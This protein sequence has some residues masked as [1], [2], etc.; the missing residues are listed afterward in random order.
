MYFLDHFLNR[1]SH[2]ILQIRRQLIV[3]TI[4]EEARI[5][6]SLSS[7]DSETDIHPEVLYFWMRGYASTEPGEWEEKYE[8]SEP[9]KY[10]SVC[11]PIEQIRITRPLAPFRQ[12]SDQFC[13]EC[14]SSIDYAHVD[15]NNELVS[16]KFTHEMLELP[17]FDYAPESVRIFK[18]HWRNYIKPG[19]FLNAGDTFSNYDLAHRAKGIKKIKA[20][21]ESSAKYPHTQINVMPAEFDRS[22]YSDSDIEHGDIEREVR[23]AIKSHCLISGFSWTAGLAH[24]NGYWQDEDITEPITTQ[25]INFDG[26]NFTF[27]GYQL[28]TIG[29]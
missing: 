29:L 26:E 22:W 12:R 21:I 24:Y 3:K 27:S 15:E 18:Q 17:W 6:A 5:L 20:G 9:A 23:E 25:L 2:V 19:Y 14:K 11:T 13:V 4:W 7:I 1:S 28:N 16:T 8:D 10:Q